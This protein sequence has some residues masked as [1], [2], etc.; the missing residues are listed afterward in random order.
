MEGVENYPR[1]KIPSIALLYILYM[2]YVVVSMASLYLCNMVMI[3]KIYILYMYLI[4]PAQLADVPL[5]RVVPRRV[6]INVSFGS[7]VNPAIFI[8]VPVPKQE[9]ERSCICVLWVL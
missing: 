1:S 3:I 7:I 9:C 4:R 6:K 8:E 2:L 5:G